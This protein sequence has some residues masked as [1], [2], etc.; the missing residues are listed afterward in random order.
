[1][2]L[3][4]GPPLRDEER[5]LRTKRIREDIAKR[6]RRAC[7]YLSDEDF[8]SLVDKMTNTQLRFEGRSR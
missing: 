8:A 1:M 6:L 2:N 3:P 7:N 4:K 5:D